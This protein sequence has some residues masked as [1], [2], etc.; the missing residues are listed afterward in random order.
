MA[1]RP[2]TVP[3]PKTVVSDGGPS[4]VFAVRCPLDGM[5]DQIREDCYADPYKDP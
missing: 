5:L 3:D 4:S 1:R 2:L